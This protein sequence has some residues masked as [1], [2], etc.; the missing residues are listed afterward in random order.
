MKTKLLVLSQLFGAMLMCFILP[1]C[2]VYDC[3]IVRCEK[4]EDYGITGLYQLNLNFDSLPPGQRFLLGPK[5]KD[6]LWE[7]QLLFTNSEPGLGNCMLYETEWANGELLPFTYGVYTDDDPENP[8][9]VDPSCSIYRYPLDAE[10]GKQYLAIKLG[11]KT[12]TTIDP[13]DCVIK[14]IIQVEDNGLTGNFEIPLSGNI[15]DD[16]IWYYGQETFNGKW[17]DRMLTDH[18]ICVNDWIQG[19]PIEFSLYTIKDG[20]KI[21]IDPSCSEYAYPPDAVPEKKHFRLILGEQRE[22]S[23]RNI[24]D[25]IIVGI[26]QRSDGKIRIYFDP[27]TLPLPGYQSLDVY[28]QS[29]PGL[30][31]IYR[32]IYDESPCY[33]VDVNW[34]DTSQPFEFTIRVITKNGDEVSIDPS[35][36]A[37]ECFGHLCLTFDEFI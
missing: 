3:C 11:E 8:I 6:G 27:T 24:D 12:T 23:K 33:Y 7:E 17:N 25:P 37:Y 36:S 32:R 4:V 2:Q 13:G 19:K 1:A 30:G 31:W 35:T 20:V 10:P 21:Y 14:D 9:Y 26:E 15:P 28:G 22:C 5:V 34:P 18:K 16:E 29:E